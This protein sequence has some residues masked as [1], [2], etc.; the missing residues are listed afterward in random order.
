MLWVFCLMLA[1]FCV[2]GS[3]NEGLSLV[4]LGRWSEA[5]RSR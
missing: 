3:Y 5:R 2:F 1:A 4:A